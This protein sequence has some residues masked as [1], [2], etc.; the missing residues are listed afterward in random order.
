MGSGS[1]KANAIAFKPVD[2]QKVAADMAFAVVG[3]MAFQRMVEPFRAKRPI[4]GN[5]QQHGRL[6]LDHVEAPGPAQAL[7]VFDK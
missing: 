2:Q 3:S 4:V 6:Q 7:P 1:D 5:Q